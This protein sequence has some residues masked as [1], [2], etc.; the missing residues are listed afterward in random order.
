MNPP[1]YRNLMSYLNEHDW[2]WGWQVDTIY[3]SY[4]CT[5]QRPQN[6]W[7]RRNAV[8]PPNHPFLWDN[9]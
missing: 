8:L 9:D 6:W 7:D 2:L 1:H 3:D 5:G 4:W